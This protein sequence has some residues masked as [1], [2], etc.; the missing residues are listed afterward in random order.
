[1]VRFMFGFVDRRVQQLHEQ[2]QLVKKLKKYYKPLKDNNFKNYENP[3]PNKI[4][5]MWLQGY[6][7]APPIVKAC[8]DSIKQY[9]NGREVIV[10]DEN[11]LFDYVEL[12]KFIIEKYHKGYISKTHFSDLVRLELLDKYGGTWIDSTMYCTDN[13]ELFLKSDLMFFQKLRTDNVYRMSNFFMHSCPNNYLIKSLKACLLNYWEKNNKLTTYFLFHLFFIVLIE[14]D[15]KCRQIWENMP[16][17]ASWLPYLLVTE[18]TKAYDEERINYLKS[19]CPVH[20]FSYKTNGFYTG[21][22]LDE[23]SLAPDCLYKRIIT[24]YEKNENSTIIPN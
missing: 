10:L 23:S 5:T 24:K 18:Y 1:M 17:Y 6:D 3:Y 16:M 14:N 2:M 8:I 13:F 21:I 20:K 19:L 7:Q 15:K 12:P 22:K 4:W 11:N 9:S